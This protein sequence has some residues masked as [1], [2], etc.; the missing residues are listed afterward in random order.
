[1][2]IA[3]FSDNFHPE[4]SGIADSTLETGTHLARRGH[5]VVFVAPRYGAKEYAVRGTAPEQP[6]PGPQA[7]VVRLPSFPFG[8][9][10]GQGRV[11]LPF[12]RALRRLPFR[13]D[14]VHVNLPFGVGIEGLMTA[15]AFGVPLVGTDHT[16]IKEFVRYSPIRGSLV[17]RCIVGFNARFYRRC[18]FVSSPCRVI[19]DE[20]GRRG[21]KAPVRKI[22]NPIRYAEFAGAPDAA[23][24][25]KRFGFGPTTVLYAG[26]L[27]PEKHV[28]VVL[29]AVAE[30]VRLGTGVDLAI[31]GRGPQEDALRKLAAELGIGHLVHFLGFVPRESMP[32]IFA[33]TEM[34]AVMS[35]AESQ[36]M[37]AMNA[38]AAGKPLIAADA[39][40]LGEY[41]REGR[42]TRVPPGSVA[43][44]ARAI[45][46]LSGSPETRT[47]CGKAGQEMVRA[48]APET[49]AEEWES[50]Y[51]QVAASYPLRSRSAGLPDVPASRPGF[52][53]PRDNQCRC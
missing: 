4:L 20:L 34:F 8:G 10:N 46:R 7:A 49:I 14:I 6:V 30:A 52:F 13:P 44:A 1:M 36:C 28:D 35:T 23:P 45:V 24:M 19:L 31:M 29:R 38:L 3:I 50:I 42:Q 32:G 15:H 48:F 41:A 18:D 51:R 17:E 43:G 53:G 5:R 16:P 33:A 12:R 37:A 21:L 40:G 39:L 22:S 26:R 9:A 25:K 47:A 2:K 11:V 27:A